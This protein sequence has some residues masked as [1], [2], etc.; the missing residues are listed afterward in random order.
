MRLLAI[1]KW[2]AQPWAKIPPPPWELLITDNPSMLEG[3]HVKLLGNGLVATVELVWQSGL[4]SPTGSAVG[5]GPTPVSR[6]V[7]VGNAP[8]SLPS[9]Q[10]F[11]PWK[12]NPF[13][14][15][16]IPAPS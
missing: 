6:V 3:L 13:P 8:P 4:A 2:C 15:T 7:P 1:C 5:S 10:G 16:V 12:S 14:R 11:A 9:L